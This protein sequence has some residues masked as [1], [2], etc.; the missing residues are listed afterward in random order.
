MSDT[1]ELLEAMG[2]ALENI[3]DAIDNLKGYP[4]LKSHFDAL[5]DVEYELLK[6]KEVLEASMNVEY[7]QQVAETVRDYYNDKL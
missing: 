3:A 7:Q 1:G 6:E 5:H 2:F 4:E